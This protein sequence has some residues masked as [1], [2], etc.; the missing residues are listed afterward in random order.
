M[1]GHGLRVVEM[2]PMWFDSF[3][4]SML[5]ERY[6]RGSN[7]LVP[8]TIA[9]LRSNVGVISGVDKCSSVI[10]IITKLSRQ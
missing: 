7:A 6:R 2:L 8:A 5:S 9:G 3:Y 1:A 4:V 10:Y